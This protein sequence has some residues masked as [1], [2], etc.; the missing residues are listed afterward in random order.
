MSSCL[1]KCSQGIRCI[2]RTLFVFLDVIDWLALSLVILSILSNHHVYRVKRYPMTDANCNFHYKHK[3]AS[4]VLV[5][6]L[7]SLYS[8]HRYGIVN[9]ITMD[10]I[11][12]IPR[13]RWDLFELYRV[14]LCRVE[15]QVLSFSINELMSEVFITRVVALVEI[16]CSPWICSK[17]TYW[18][19]RLMLLYFL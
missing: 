19:Q 7:L 10:H 9:M 18:V 1:F 14:S 5:F 11:I 3:F 12:P 6:L 17:K 4:L 15:H 16:R 8:S 2:R 13:R